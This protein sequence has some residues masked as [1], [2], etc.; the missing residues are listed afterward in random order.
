[1]KTAIKRVT[2]IAAALAVT[3]VSGCNEINQDVPSK[4]ILEAAS[5]TFDGLAAEGYIANSTVFFDNN[6]NGSLDAW[7]A[8]AYTDADGYLSYNPLTDTNYCAAGATE[9]EQQYCLQTKQ[10]FDSVIMRINGGISSTSVRP[11]GGQLSRTISDV[12]A[13]TSVTPVISPFTSL[14]THAVTTQQDTLL[15]LLGV[16]E[17]E[18][19]VNYLNLP[20]KLSDGT[21]DVGVYTELAGKA[22]LIH[23][24]VVV[25]NHYLGES[26]PDLGTEV[27]MPYDASNMIYKHLA[28]QLLDYGLTLETAVAHAPLLQKVVDGVETD[29]RDVLADA[30]FNLPSGLSPTTKADIIAGIAVLPTVVSYMQ[31]FAIND[32]DS[33]KNFMQVIDEVVW[34]Y[35]ND[36]VSASG[37]GRTASVTSR[38]ARQNAVDFKDF[39][40]QLTTILEQA[41]PEVRDLEIVIEGSGSNVVVTV[42]DEDVQNEVIEGSDDLTVADLV[43]SINVTL[44]HDDDGE[45]KLEELADNYD[46]STLNTFVDD[47]TDLQDNID[48]LP[49]FAEL[50]G[51]SIKI[52]DDDLGR[53]GA[54]NDREIEMYFDANGRLAACAK[55][56]ED[57][58]GGELDIDDFWGKYGEGSWT[59]VGDDQRTISV[60]YEVEEGAK[61]QGYF[62]MLPKE[63]VDGVE[64]FAYKG[65]FSAS[66]G[67]QSVIFYSE[68]GLLDAAE[69]NSSTPSTDAECETRL[70]RRI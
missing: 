42:N 7:E 41:L 52:S 46:E 40:S 2:P 38:A 59:I 65:A 20:L 23:K 66:D 63:V 45:N 8:F 55:K 11:I 62:S 28:M 30:D 54:Q 43:D 17:A 60:I 22:L 70:G 35:L 27:G 34:Q 67:N 32:I 37:S 3:L 10:D 5:K 64:K 14:L 57:Y 47:A 58:N 36:E 48:T 53:P 13:N 51:K 26:Y 6:N 25:M 39:L 12:S 4:E 61:L 18:L 69:S 29:V 56:V 1:M 68:D 21:D 9:V 15:D 33:I 16:S 24:V 49:T 19:D 50:A 44:V 31:A